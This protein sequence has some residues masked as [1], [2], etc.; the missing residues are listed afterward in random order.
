M[1]GTMF[2]GELWANH[3]NARFLK[4]NKI[5]MTKL[6]LMDKLQ[7]IKKEYDDAHRTESQSEIDVASCRSLA[8]IHIPPTPALRRTSNSNSIKSLEISAN[9][10]KI[11]SGLRL[12]KVTSSRH[13]FANEM[14]CLENCKEK[15][16][17]VERQYFLRMIEIL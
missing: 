8:T 3:D 11:K 4:E 5:H 17:H 13:N 6:K 10:E 15:I 2:V 7:A 16:D 1:R 9:L 14:K 12:L